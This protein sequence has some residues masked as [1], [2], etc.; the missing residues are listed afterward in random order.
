M[1]ISRAA[2]PYKVLHARGGQEVAP[3]KFFDELA[4]ASAICLGETHPNPHDH[5]AQLHMLQ[6]IVN[7]RNG[8]KMALGMEMFQLP[9]Q[10]VLDDY[11]AGRIDENTMLSRTDWANRWGFDFALYRPLMN[12]AIKQSIPILALN[13]SAELKDKIK[14]RG[15]DGLTPTDR[16]MVP[17]I[18]LDDA[19]HRAWFE[20]LMADMGSHG[21]GQSSGEDKQLAQQI[22]LSQV[23]WDETMADTATRWVK[24]E[25]DRHVIIIAGSGHCHDSA[26]VRRMQR[27]GAGSVISIRP[28]MQTKVADELA[29]PQ[30]DYLFVLIPPH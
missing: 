5:W 12:L 20:D 8:R 6:E 27:R 28:V 16:A 13:I 30:T 10:G 18:N 19:E 26:I 14:R 2:L 3:E 4:A 29:S 7:R 17:E 25:A 9:F 15:I 24:G 11:A 1:D 22:Y 23:L 21:H